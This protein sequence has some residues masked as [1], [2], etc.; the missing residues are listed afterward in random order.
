LDAKVYFQIGA[1]TLHHRCVV[2]YHPAPYFPCTVTQIPTA[3]E[4]FTALTINC[5]QLFREKMHSNWFH[6]VEILQGRWQHGEEVGYRFPS[7]LTKNICLFFIKT[8][9]LYLLYLKL[10]NTRAVNCVQNTAWRRRKQTQ[11]CAARPYLSTRAGVVKHVNHIN[12]R[13]SALRGLRCLRLNVRL[14]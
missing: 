4:I 3:F 13:R 1:V 10:R 7:G 9:F 12:L 11:N 8:I 6:G 14:A 5:T 2:N